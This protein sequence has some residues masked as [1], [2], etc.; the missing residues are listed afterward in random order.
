[1]DLSRTMGTDN[2][3]HIIKYLSLMACQ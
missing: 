3:C 1:M 2:H